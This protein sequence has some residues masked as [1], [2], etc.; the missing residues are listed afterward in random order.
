[1]QSCNGVLFPE[2]AWSKEENELLTKLVKLHNSDPDYKAKKIEYP[3]KNIHWRSIA[4]IMGTRD[5]YQCCNTW[6]DHAWA[7]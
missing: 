2:G 4:K 7:Q 6:Y 3:D 1:M 5:E